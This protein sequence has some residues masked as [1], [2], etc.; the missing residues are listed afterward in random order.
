MLSHISS[1]SA[2]WGCFPTITALPYWT[3]G[4]VAALMRSVQRSGFISCVCA[5]GA[6]QG[7]RERADGARVYRWHTLRVVLAEIRGRE[8]SYWAARDEDKSCPSLMCL[9]WRFSYIF[10]SFSSLAEIKFDE[11]CMEP[12]MHF[13]RL[14]RQSE[15]VL[16]NRCLVLGICRAYPCFPYRLLSLFFLFQTDAFVLQSCVGRELPPAQ[17]YTFYIF[18]ETII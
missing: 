17:N 3:G 13:S 2:G 10:V 9:L 8:R 11:Y 4:L 15:A 12:G 1:G 14:W 6:Q 5:N 7:S 18:V 16:D